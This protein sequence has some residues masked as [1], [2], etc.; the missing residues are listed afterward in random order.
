MEAQF[1][2]CDYKKAM[3]VMMVLKQKGSV[4]EYY[5]EFLDTKCQL[6]MHNTAVNEA[7]FI[8]HFV[9]GLREDLKAAVFS[10]DPNK[11]ERAVHLAILQED[12]FIP[13]SINFLIL[14][15]LDGKIKAFFICLIS[16]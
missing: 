7:F 16:S 1:G 6:H 5:Q 2:T 4:R 15:K 12:I 10:Q 13:K 9:K 3:N 8:Q 11:L 14:K